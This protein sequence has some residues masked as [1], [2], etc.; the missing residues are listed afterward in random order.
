MRRENPAKR[1]RLIKLLCE[2]I[3][4]SKRSDRDL[5]KMLSTSQPTVTRLRKVLEKEAILQYT[6]I[7]NLPYLGFDI[8]AFTFMRSKELVHPLVEKGKKWAKEK[9]N[10]VFA[11]TGQG[12]DSDAVIV[13]IHKDYADFVKFYQDFRT[14]WG[15]HLHDFKNFFIS[16]K[17]SF[18]MK[19]FS[20]N[21]LAECVEE[22]MKK[23]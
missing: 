12:I 16:L 9:P 11:C 20:L 17:G 21:H 8:L 13:S 3:K 4:N 23:S 1:E 22:E 15:K 7:P 19:E 5:A 10:V 18:M 2:L 6:L 14:D